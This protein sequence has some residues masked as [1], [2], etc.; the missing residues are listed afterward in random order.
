MIRYALSMIYLVLAIVA[1]SAPA[2]TAQKIPGQPDPAKGMELAEKLCSNCHLGKGVATSVGGQPADVPSFPEIAKRPGQTAERIHGKLILPN[3]PMPT[4]P[5]TEDEMA[6]LA[7]Y[8]L[9]LKSAD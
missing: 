3:H 5:L 4:I 6:D 1:G 7:A 9:S 2:A 8:I